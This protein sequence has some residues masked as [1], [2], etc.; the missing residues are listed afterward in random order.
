MR[1]A[2]SMQNVVQRVA[3]IGLGAGALARPAQAA[4]T[5]L[6]FTILAALIWVI[7]VREGGPS[8]EDSSTSSGSI[9]T[10]VT[11]LLSRSGVGPGGS[12]VLVLWATPEYFR[13]TGQAALA[14][15]YGA[16]SHLVFFIWENIH[17]GDLAETMRPVLRVNG[18]ATYLPTDVLVPA[19]AVH[20]RFSVMRYA[21]ADAL[22]A[23]VIAG[24]ARLV[25][26]I[27]PP[28]RNGGPRS[29]MAWTLPLAYPLPSG[30]GL[31]LTGA[32]VLALLGGVLASMWP[33]LLQLTV[34]FIP[35]L[36]GV[37]MAQARSDSGADRVHVVKTAALFVVGFV[38]VYTAAGAAAGAAAQS[39]TGAAFWNLRR[40]FSIVA[41]LVI[42]FMALRVAVNAR[43]PL[44]CRM[45]AA[46]NLGR[47]QNGPVGTM[48]LG[49]AFAVGCTTCFGA[50]L[51]LGIVAYAGLTATPLY[52]A[53]IM[54]L[55]SLGMAVPLLAGAAAM[56]RVLVLLGRLEKV[57]PWMALASSLI[58]AAFGV[59]L[60]SGRFM[61][62]SN[63][64]FS[65]TGF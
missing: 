48:L 26:L 61:T 56:A 43:A 12:D 47:W 39:L 22:A 6:I 62:V 25:E 27:L 51:I 19:E 20:H 31:Q 38:I 40:P 34:Y 60:L 1:G 17:D 5:A 29:E 65:R 24:D 49:L 16:D 10:A 46:V 8:P 2:A 53:V 4:R 57:A 32:S 15:H 23:P 11:S 44:V 54:F 64:I 9:A 42:L 33:C 50:A 7:V 13:F 52:G 37:S 21:R 55:F 30:S 14:T 63:W 58:M 35:S 18:G 28:A 3:R 36:A 59:L 41:G 45:P